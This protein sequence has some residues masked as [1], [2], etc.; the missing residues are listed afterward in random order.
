MKHILFLLFLLSTVFGFK[1]KAQSDS[2]NWL[3]EVVLS[4]VKLK[5]N[6]EGQ[7][8]IPL[9]DSL[10]QRSEPLLASLLKYNSPFFFR[11]NGYG[12]VA[13]AS[14]RGT[15]AAQTAVIWNGI[16]IN[17]Q[18]TGQTDFNAVN[19][20]VFDEISLRPGG[21]SVIYGSGAIGGTIHL[22]NEFKFDD[23][24]S[25]RINLGYGSFDTYQANYTGRI[26][27]KST[28]L[29]I[30][31]AGISSDNDYQYPG[32]EAYNE[33]GD[34]NNISVNAS[35]AHWIGASDIL[36][37][38]SNYYEGARGFSGT[39]NLDSNSS[40]EDRNSRNLL[41][42]KNFSGKYT[43]SV[44]LAWIQEGFKYFE[45][46]DSENFSSGEAETA[47]LK[48]DLGYEISESGILNFTVDYTDVSGEG[49]GIDRA[50]RKIGGAS[51]IWE[52]DV[53][54]L[55]YELSLRQEI[56]ENYNS[57]LL[58]AAGV[59]YKFSD[60]YLIRF[61]SSRN[62][63]MPTFNDLFWQNGGNDELEP[64]TSLQGEIGAEVKFKN[65]N[66][67]LTTYYIDINELIRWIPDDNGQ[68]RPVNTAE[69]YNYG[70]ETF[71]EWSSELFN[72]R[73][74]LRGNYAFTRS[75]DRRR[76]KQLIYT[77]LHKATFSTAYAVGDLSILFQSLYNGKIF[78]S[79]D[80]LYE[81]DGYLLATVGLDYTL[82]TRPKMSLGLQIENVFNKKYES[83]PSRIMPGRSVRT[84]LTL[85]F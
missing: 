70:I 14:V 79:T 77:P 48:Y 63:R 68:W 4:D 66:F 32:T 64:E 60:Q 75:I 59:T 15:G 38:H 40:Y 54:Q 58:Y 22:S 26:S 23:I 11:E 52:Q 13:S 65:L 17:S 53:D 25:N 21:G 83:L 19:T 71:A 30:G 29:N 82:K 27:N 2:L 62:F 9:T 42:W 34:F 35:I 39:L 74:A 45:N 69:V 56:T 18:F 24:S 10:I 51:A 84:T 12:M 8:V 28:S 43:H 47:I 61:S 41:E 78:T 36:K 49:S 46:R 33:N 81:V 5:Q 72:N 50:V 20:R 76:G 85:N 67:Q 7:M 80:N 6:S 3:E 57:P 37:F 44:K 31:V 1:A 73:I 55:K 16:N